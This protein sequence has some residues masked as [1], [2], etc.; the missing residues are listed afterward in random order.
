MKKEELISGAKRI[1][2]SMRTGQAKEWG[3]SEVQYN[4]KGIYSGKVS[5][6]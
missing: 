5:A 1:S 6:P 3:A 2:G 4:D